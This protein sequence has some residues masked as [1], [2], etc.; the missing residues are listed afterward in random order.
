MKKFTFFKGLLAFI[1]ITALSANKLAAQ[2]PRTVTLSPA[3]TQNI[4]AGGTVAFTATRNSNSSFWTGGNDNFTYT[5]SSSPAGVTFTNNPVTISGNNSSTTATFPSGGTFLITCFVQEGGGGGNATSPATTV[6]VTVP[7]PSVS[8]TPSIAQNI[9]AGG[10][11][12]FTATAVNFGGSGNY[13]HTWTAAGA[14][15]PGSN[16]NSGAS[17]TNAKT[18][19]FPTAG[20]Y[21]VS[22][23]ISRGG[24]GGGTLVTNTTTV[25][26]FNP[27]AAANLW[28][29]SGDGNTVSTFSVSSGVYF[30]GPT[31]LFDPFPSSTETTAALGRNDKPSAA[32]GHFY[33]MPN[34]GANGVMNLYA[35]TSTG[36]SRTLIGTLDVN[37]A[38]NNNLGF[39]RLGMGPDGTGWI[40][41]GDGSTVYL[42]KFTSNGVNPVT[43]TVEDASVTL[44][45]GAASTFQNGDICISGN[46]NIYALAN[47]G[48]GVTQIFIGL[49]AGSS[50]TLTKKWDLT[51]NTNSPFNGRVNGVAFDL[52]GSLYIS[53]DD[54]LFFINQ[55]TVNGPAGTVSCLLVRSQTG[56]QDLASN[57]FPTQSLLPAKLIS[58]GATYKNQNTLLNWVTENLENFSHF[59]VERSSD[60]SNFASV[61]S[62]QPMGNLSDRTTYTHTDNLALQTG[63]VFYYRLKMV[64]I[65][66]D[67]KYSAI[68]LI[69]KDDKAITGIRLSPN[70]VISG[71]AATVRFEMAANAT[72]DFKVVDLNGRIVLSQQNVVYEGTNSV[73]I[74]NLN[75]LQPGMYILQMSSGNTTEMTKF[76]IAR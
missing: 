43:I 19:T 62:K 41:A 69:R 21:T 71:A 34:D 10:T 17:A 53:T 11:V 6:N 66:G 57:V 46:G 60:G 32:L 28:A 67:F 61:A 36:T 31:T 63:N 51:D 39:V 25:N 65:N 8:L 4:S 15:I 75:R 29:T 58:F 56:L 12:A 50:T 48:G 26:V 72:V 73:A 70:P 2:P 59:E 30:A 7:V 13:T 76:S 20:T 1:L 33:W 74:A 24:V 5:W 54:G 9:A 37:G 45:G 22:V 42:A 14:T 55:N 68:I 47:D 49:P 23:T 3:T 35:A 44:A 27:P 16:P 52:L 64:D 18:L 40:L 38:S